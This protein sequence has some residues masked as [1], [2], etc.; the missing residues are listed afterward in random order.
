MENIVELKNLRKT[1][2]Q[3]S[4]DKLSLH[5]SPG[6]IL[7]F[8]GPNGAGK[9]T[10]LK[11]M[12]NMVKPD[13]GEIRIFGLNHPKHIKEIKKKI[14]YV[15]ENQYF[16]GD[17]SVA[18]TGKFVSGFYD[19]WD[20]NR[21]QSLLSDFAISRTKKTRELSQGM[22]LKLSLALALSHNPDLLILDEPTAGLDPVIRR[23]VLEI[24]LKLSR[25]EDKSV[26]ISSHIT[27]DIARIADQIIFL[28]KGKIAL[29]GEKD[30][31]LSQWKR[32][33]Y[34]DDALNE[35]IIETL[36]SRQAHMF[37]NSGITDNYL[38][39]KDLLADGIAQESIKVENVSLDDILIAYIKGES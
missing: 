11:I 6:N 8:I 25:A 24:F 30:E 3:F 15:G 1:Y 5:L 27:N 4:L 23:D 35:Q 12:M 16:Y 38:K 14:G 31:I 33:H 36:R 37:G 7:G 26:I 19:S 10:T 17:K 18:W 20:T 28:I 39:I 29:W 13:S 2:R 21:F 34:Q 32:I 22:K 9:T